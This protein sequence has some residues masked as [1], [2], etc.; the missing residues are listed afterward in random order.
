MDADATNANIKCVHCGAIASHFCRCCAKWVC[1]NPICNLK[2][3]YECIA[4][5]AQKLFKGVFG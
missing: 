5:E 1:M 3:A 4:I 2:S